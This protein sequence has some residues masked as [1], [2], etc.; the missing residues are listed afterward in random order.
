MND[1]L[2]FSY[3]TIGGLLSIKSP[4]DLMKKSDMWKIVRTNNKYVQLCVIH[5]NA[6]AEK[7]CIYEQMEQKKEK[8]DYI[9]Y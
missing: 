4:D 1:I 2:K 7:A 9:L 5:L 8:E 3:S 6:A